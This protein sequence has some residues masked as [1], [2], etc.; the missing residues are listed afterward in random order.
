MEGGD[1][2]GEIVKG[3]G[4]LGGVEIGVVVVPDSGE[5]CC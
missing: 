4:F 1:C 2:G 3:V 5:D